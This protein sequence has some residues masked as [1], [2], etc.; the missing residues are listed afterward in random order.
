MSYRTKFV[1]KLNCISSA[2][3][4]VG[5]AND[6]C[7]TIVSTREWLEVPVREN[8]RTL[9]RE[10]EFFEKKK[11]TILKGINEYCNYKNFIIIYFF[12][13]SLQCVFGV[14]LDSITSYLLHT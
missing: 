3:V 11:K 4:E 10:D 2:T 9:W 6:G 1:F 13:V 5:L 7:Q 8:Q 14:K 12:K